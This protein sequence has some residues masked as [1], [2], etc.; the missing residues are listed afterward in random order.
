[1]TIV[2]SD[3]MRDF[4]EL[5]PVAAVG[6][7]NCLFLASNLRSFDLPKT[8]FMKKIILFLLLTAGSIGHSFGQCSSEVR[9][10]FGG[11]ASIALYNTYITIGAV[12]DG[13]VA[14]SYDS[15]RVQTL[16]DEQV[17]MINV[18]ID[19]LNKAIDDPS[20]S[21][22]SDDKDY[23][24]EM[25]T[26]LNYLKAEAQG[27][28]DIALYGSDDASNRYNTNRD[29]AWTSIELLLGLGDD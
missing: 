4:D 18:L 2:F 22:T 26:C 14:E 27:L 16:M 21:L 10:A 24:R 12:A 29:L 8:A 6:P 15:E 17:S 20:E 9:E 28:H 19:F 13:Y 7:L 11:T 3:W 5:S 23:L 25:I 1:M